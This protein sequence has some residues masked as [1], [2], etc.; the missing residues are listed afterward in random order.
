ML[1]CPRCRATYP[2]NLTECP[3]DGAALLPSEML[4]ATEPPLEPGTMVGEYRVD[5]KL[6]SGS[7]GD[8]Y[9]GEQ[10]LIGK[11]VAIKLLHRKFSSDAEVVSRFVAEARAVN[12]IRHRHIIDIFSFGLLAEN[13]HYF[14][15]ELLDGL[16]LGELLEREGRLSLEVALPIFRGIASA[17]DAAHEAGITHRDLK[18]DNV[19]LAV[20]KEGGY[21]SKLLDFGI[22][23]LV[24]DDAAHRTATGIAIGTPRYMSPEQCR[25]KKVDHR[26]D[27]YSLGAVIHEVLSGQPLFDGE[28]TMDVFFKHMNEP[29]PAMSAVRPGL[30][31]ELDEPVLAMLAKRPKQRPESAGAAV[32]AL[33]KRAQECGQTATS[34]ISAGPGGSGRAVITAP[35][36]R[37]ASSDE[38]T[39]AVRQRGPSTPPATS[40][41]AARSASL[42]VDISLP[43]DTDAEDDD[44]KLTEREATQGST[45]IAPTSLASGTLLSDAT[46][47]IRDEAPS[48]R[49]VVTMRSPVPEERGM[50]A[51]ARPSRAGGRTRGAGFWALLA[52]GAA[53]L[54]AGAIALSRP[55]PE[56]TSI[57]ATSLAA[58]SGSGSSTAVAPDVTPTPAPTGTVTVRMTVTPSDAAVVIGDRRVGGAGEPLV[59]PRSSERQAVRL[60]H[61]GYEPKTVWVVPDHDLEVPAVVLARAV[62]SAGSGSSKPL[63]STAPPGS[64]TAAASG[65]PLAKPDFNDIEPPKYPR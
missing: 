5:R 4:P 11:R 42:T 9:A 44:E 17:L 45:E 19:F 50:Q 33:I 23:K 32:A 16:T 13:R 20:E 47:G 56:P 29:A 25:G 48:G 30:P 35:G 61:E 14:V 51:G 3:E 43:A 18:P 8:V 38:A 28:S 55:S 1:A 7:F 37:L 15:M 36:N 31:V 53:A 59:L 58:P 21:F 34:P 10:P 57:L 24:T 60:E 62:R 22:A 52:V 40:P 12:R 6:G 2:D 54:I 39:V 46:S 41:A 65:K 27:I 26:A 64:G 49:P 63:S